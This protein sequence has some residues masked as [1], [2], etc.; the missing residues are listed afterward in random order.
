MVAFDFDSDRNRSHGRYSHT[1]E[2]QVPYEWD[3]AMRLG[4]FFSESRRS[5]PKEALI[6][7]GSVGPHH[8]RQW[9][10]QVDREPLRAARWFA[11]YD[12]LRRQQPTEQFIIGRDGMGVRFYNYGEALDVPSIQECRDFTDAASGLFGMQAVS[13]RLSDVVLTRLRID[14]ETKR[15]NLGYRSSEFPGV[16]FI[17]DDRRAFA[18]RSSMFHVMA[19]EFGHTFEPTTHDEVKALRQFSEQLGWNMCEVVR[20][21][22]EWYV[23]GADLKPADLY[24]MPPHD[25]A[26]EVISAYAQTNPHESLAEAVALQLSGG[27]ASVPWLQNALQEYYDRI[28][29]Q[30]SPLSA[31]VTSMPLDID[32]RCD[33]DILY[34]AVV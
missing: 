4:G 26:S 19:H 18:G 1:A 23:S 15:Q 12:F 28:G 11:Q 29:I 5:L 24:T 27:L 25:G 34:P 8:E 9:W 20:K 14:P 17:H 32:R 3:M 31:G 10:D 6:R 21:E 2:Q 16:I 30:Y 7:A 22:P 33:D 13:E